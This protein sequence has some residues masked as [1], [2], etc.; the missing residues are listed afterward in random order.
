MIQRS[1]KFFL[2]FVKRGSLLLA[3]TMMKQAKI[4]NVARPATS[5]RRVSS[6]RSVNVCEERY[7]V[8]SSSTELVRMFLVKLVTE[9]REEQRHCRQGQR[10]SRA[11]SVFLLLSTSAN[12]ATE[13]PWGKTS[14]RGASICVLVPS[15]GR[16]KAAQ[17][18]T[19]FSSLSLSLSLC[20]CVWP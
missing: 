2:P 4:E 17:A 18:R 5:P 8:A 13:S 15:L 7:S 16:T 10:T 9:K 1:R 20:L 12:L 19:V 3:R 11:A 6:C 14:D